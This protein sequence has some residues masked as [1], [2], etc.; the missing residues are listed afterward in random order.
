MSNDILWLRCT[1]C[2]E[3]LLIAKVWGGGRIAGRPGAEGFLEEHNRKHWTDGALGSG[4]LPPF[5]I[6]SEI[7]EPAAD[8]VPRY[9]IR[10]C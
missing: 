1:V 7:S 3:R 9:E 2:G 8:G 10:P 4:R 5:V 6:D